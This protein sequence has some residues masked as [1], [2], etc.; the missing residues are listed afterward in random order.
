MPFIKMKGVDGLVY[1][2]DT[3]GLSDKKHPCTDCE[4]C[5][6]CSDARCKICLGNPDCKKRKRAQY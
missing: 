5:Q 3:E 2:P 6:H 4:S 1:V